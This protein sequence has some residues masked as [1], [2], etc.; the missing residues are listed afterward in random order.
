[1]TSKLDYLKKYMGGGGRGDVAT[2]KKKIRKSIK[3]GKCSLKVVDDD[4]HWN[5]RGKAANDDKIVWGMEEDDEKPTIVEED[6]DERKISRGTWAEVEIYQIRKQ[7]ISHSPP[8]RRRQDSDDESPPRRKNTSSQGASDSPPRRRRQDCDDES[9]RP[10]VTAEAI[11][12]SLDQRVHEEKGI[13]KMT[14]TASGHNAGLQSGKDFGETEKDLKRKRSEEL[15]GIDPTLLGASVETVYRDKKGKKLDMLTEFMKQQ[16]VTETKKAKIEEAQ[17]EW[18][19]G[20]VQRE[21][22]ELARKELDEIAEGPFARTI[23]DPKLEMYKKSIIRD[24]D[25]MAEYIREKE[26]ALQAQHASKVGIIQ[27]PVYKGPAPPPNRF[28]IRPGYRWDGIPRGN[29]FE[30]KLLTRG[31]DKAALREDEYRWSVSDM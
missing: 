13:K 17:Y 20:S 4:D 19:K 27:K 5:S 1:M 9:P 15:K 30:H 12:T 31:N 26:E 29:G 11:V 7:D 24:G 23:D 10:R 16:A 8:R 21:N 22:V 3:S 18:G 6:E 2:E 14:K 25:P 28:G